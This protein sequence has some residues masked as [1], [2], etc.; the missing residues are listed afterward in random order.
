[1]EQPRSG[2]G[3]ISLAR[4]LALSHARR[5]KANETYE[6]GSWRWNH[7]S[8]E[9]KGDCR[10]SLVTKSPLDNPLDRARTSHG[11][12]RGGCLCQCSCRR[13]WDSEILTL[14]YHS[15]LPSLLFSR[16]F[17]RILHQATS[18]PAMSG[19]VKPGLGLPFLRPLTAL[20]AGNGAKINAW[21]QRKRQVQAPTRGR[22][23]DTKRGKMTIL[24]RTTLYM[25][26]QAKE[27]HLSA[28]VLL[29]FFSSARESPPEAGP[30]RSYRSCHATRHPKCNAASSL[31]WVCASVAYPCG[32]RRERADSHLLGA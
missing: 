12:A 3:H 29:S 1:M 4:H 2:N 6:Q 26:E 8:Q 25:S 11:G 20:R 21:R 16:S 18:R 32:S 19:R 22:Q 24:F 17:P 5:S 15:C 30:V 14:L 31:P 28:S 7:Q 9:P 27:V 23:T 13:T 10:S